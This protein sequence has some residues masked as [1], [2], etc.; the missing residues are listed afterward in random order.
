MSRDLRMGLRQYESPL[1]PMYHNNLPIHI[2]RARE[3]HEFTDFTFICGATRFQVHKVIV[4]SQSKVFHAACT[5]PF[6]VSLLLMLMTV[7]NI[8]QESSTNEFD[9]S[10]FSVDHVKWL[11]DFLY[12]G[13]YQ[14]PKDSNLDDHIY[15]FAIGDMYRIEPL[16]QHAAEKFHCGLTHILML[17]EV[18]PL[19]P[20]VYNSTPEHRQELRQEVVMFLRSPG[21]GIKEEMESRGW[22]DDMAEE[23]PDFIKD[24]L[25]SYLEWSD[26]DWSFLSN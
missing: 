15:M 10:E 4:C 7:V 22:Y 25:F 1:I 11:I 19:I 13:T 9:L 18:L 21:P 17:E 23:C 8:P 6:K 2:Y 16:A 14:T 26:R 12:M 5:G 24:L 3:N 20:L